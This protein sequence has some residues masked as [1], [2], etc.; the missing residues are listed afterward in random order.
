MVYEPAGWSF[1]EDERTSPERSGLRA[2][3]LRSSRR[4]D[5]GRW[6]P[7]VEDIR[8]AFWENDKEMLSGLPSRQCGRYRITSVVVRLLRLSFVLPG[9]GA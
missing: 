2:R 8:T 6:L 1:S 4:E 5:C 9:L 3:P 7:F